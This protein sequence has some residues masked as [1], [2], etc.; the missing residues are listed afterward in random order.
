MKQPDGSFIPWMET[1]TG[2]KA[3]EAAAAAMAADMKDESSKNS[4]ASVAGGENK[5]EKTEK[6][7]AVGAEKVKPNEKCSCD[8]GK[9]YKKC[10]GAN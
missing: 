4:T 2:A 10:C 5:P 8:S 9:K 6:A 1:K 7:A 3:N